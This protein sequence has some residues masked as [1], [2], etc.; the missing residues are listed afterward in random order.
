MQPT[1]EKRRTIVNFGN[2]AAQGRLG[3][4]FRRHVGKEEQLTVAGA[5]DQ[6]EFLAFVHD[7]ETRIAHPV[8]AAHRFK[9]LLP[10][11]PVR[12]VGEHEVE[13]LCRKSVVRKRGPFRAADNMAGALALAFE[14]HV[15]LA[16][17]VGLRVDFLAIELALDLLAALRANRR[18]RLLPHGEHSSSAASA[19]VE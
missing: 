15:R 14:E 1:S 19:V 16:D 6:R 2:P 4:H 3:V 12:R 11:L 8:L 7:L 18:E 5:R 13:F 9:V 10:A 17:G